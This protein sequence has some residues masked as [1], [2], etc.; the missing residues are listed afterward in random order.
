MLEVDLLLLFKKDVFLVVG[1][2]KRFFRSY[3]LND[4]FYGFLVDFENFINVL[5]FK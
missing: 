2:L 1:I 5:L 3:D 4:E